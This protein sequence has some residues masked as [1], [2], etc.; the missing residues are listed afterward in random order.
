VVSIT[1]GY[2]KAKK[3]LIL[4]DYDGTLKH[5]SNSISAS[6]SKPSTRLRAQLVRIAKQKNVTLCI[7]SGRPKSTL[8][9]W[10]K[11]IPNIKLIAEH[12]A[13][14]KEN[15]EWKQTAAAFDKKAVVETLKHYAIRTAGSVVEEKDFSVVW[16]YRRVSPELAYIRN[17][18]IK[19]E[20]HRIGLS[21]D[22]G[23]FLGNK[24]IEVKPKAIN[25]GEV[26][27]EL[28][29][30]YPSDFVF[31]AGD[32]YTDE[33]MFESLPPSANTVKVGYGETSARYQVGKLERVLAIIEAFG[34]TS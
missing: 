30:K 4:L 18:E 19:R 21:D 8:N 5:F 15:G 27:K 7:I 34:R 13:W 17:D 33:D 23:V 32:D 29:L 2:K 11:N 3:R 26:A 31:C 25:K 12:G 6:A 1:D 22:I 9:A 24:I 28:L 10:F 14:T 20:L 16:H